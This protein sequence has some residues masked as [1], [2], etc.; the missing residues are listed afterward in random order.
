MEQIELHEEALKEAQG[1]LD[2][3]GLSELDGLKIRGITGCDDAIRSY[4]SHPEGL[5]SIIVESIKPL[6]GRFSK[7]WM[8]PALSTTQS[9]S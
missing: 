1:Q 2:I 7:R 5:R 3:V 4:L 9:K 6:S 8:T